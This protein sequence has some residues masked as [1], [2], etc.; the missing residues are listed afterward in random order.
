LSAACQRLV[1]APLP[2]EGEHPWYVLVEAAGHDDPTAALADAM[3]DVADVAV[4]GPGEPARRAQLWL[5]REGIT[6][7]VNRVGPPTKLDVTL[8][9]PALDAF[10]TEVVGA[11]APPAQVWLF[12]HVG[13]GNVHVNVT[14]VDPADDAVDDAV[15][16]LVVAHGGSISAEHGIGRAK[17]PWLHLVRSEAELA[18]FGRIK[19]ALDPAGILNPAVLLPEA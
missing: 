1:G 13:D 17:R 12:G 19:R 8:P 4:A 14:G 15:L 11:A 6:E 10:C 3:S 18:A 5:H 9:G 7:A 2:L 16:R